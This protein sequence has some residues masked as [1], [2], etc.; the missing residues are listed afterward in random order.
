MKFLVE[1]RYDSA[2]RKAFREAFESAGFSQM[3]GASVQG[4]WISTKEYLVFLLAESPD[5]AKVD[6]ACRIWSQFGQWT[7]HPVMD[8]EQL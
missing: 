7:I 2:Q 8:L 6:Q 3:E 1:F 4:A 5:A